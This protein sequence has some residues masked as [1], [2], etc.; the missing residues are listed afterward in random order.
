MN[1]S[2]L[3]FQ[4]LHVNQCF[5]V[6]FQLYLEFRLS[7]LNQRF[8]YF[9]WHLEFLYFHALLCFLCFQSHLSDQQILGFLYFHENQ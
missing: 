3:E 9:Q 5:H 7:L 6:Q 2:H 8:P 4:L 1:L